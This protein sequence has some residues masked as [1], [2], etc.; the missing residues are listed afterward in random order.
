MLGAITG[1]TKAS[2]RAA[3]TV[4][5]VTSVSGFVTLV[6]TGGNLEAASTVASVET[7]GTSAFN[8]GFTGHLIDQGLTALQKLGQATDFAQSGA[9]TIGLKT[10]PKC[11]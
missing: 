10:T 5:T 9:D 7:L 3:A 6:A 1:N 8:G 4:T 2:D 11:P